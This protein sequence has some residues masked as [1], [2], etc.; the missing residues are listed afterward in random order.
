MGKVRLCGSNVEKLALSEIYKAY[1]SVYFVPKGQ[2]NQPLT[3]I[4]DQ[5]VTERNV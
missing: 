5:I 4:A 2:I 1:V 3:V